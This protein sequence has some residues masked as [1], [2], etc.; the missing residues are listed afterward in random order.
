MNDWIKYAVLAVYVGILLAI[1]LFA[2]KKSRTVNDFYLAGRNIGPWISAFSYAI[3]YFSAVVFIGYAGKIGWGFGL[4]SLWIVFGNAVIGGLLAW[5]VLAKPTRNMTTRLGA[6]TMPEFLSKRYDSP[7]IKIFAALVIFI[8]M[9]PYSSS[10]YMG[11]SYFFEALFDI[12]YWAA[13]LVMAGI[14]AIFLVMGGYRA[15]NWSDMFMG[16]L[17]FAGVGVLLVNIL[18]APQVGGLSN[19]VSRLSAIDPQLTSLWGPDALSGKIALVSLVILTSLGVWGMPQMTQKFYAIKNEKAIKPAT[20]VSFVFCLVIA[21]GAYFTGSLSRL[22]FTTEQYNAEPILGGLGGNP[23]LLVPS[24]V[25]SALPEYAALFIL[26]LILAAS[27]STLSSLV[28][29]SASSIAVDFMGKVKPNMPKKT[30]MFLMRALCVVFALVSFAVAL[31]KIEVIVTLMAFS[32]GA[33]A[34]SFLAPYIYGLF[35][36][37]GTRGAAWI[38]MVCG[39]S[40]A[41]IFSLLFPK[42]VPLVGSLAMLVPLIVFPIAS[43]FTKPLPEEHVKRVFDK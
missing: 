31:G 40:I 30:T 28:L 36:K 1:G 27:M 5:I 21:F 16:L 25:S 35:Y 4:S 6:I 13:L 19:V 39:L 20:I 11:L 37:K 43:R 32:W 15:V 33:I 12:P 22:F 17:M 23:D 38:S 18:G 3:T 29:V 7:G 8:F 9:V 2:M 34:G 42:H 26:L 14:T 10:V 41:A 24:M